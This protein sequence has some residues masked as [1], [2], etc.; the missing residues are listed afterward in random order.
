MRSVIRLTALLFLTCLIAAPALAQQ[1][2]TV[3]GTV[4]NA[5]GKAVAG[6]TIT[7]EAPTG[8]RETRSGPDGKFSMANVPSGSYTLNVRADGFV[9]SRTTLAVSA[10][11]ATLEV[12]L[13]PEP[14]FTEV[15]SV[16]PN[17]RSA[18]ESYQPTTVLG[19]QDLAVNLKGTLGATLD[20]EPG[21]ATRS[22]GP[23]PARPVIRGLDG[24]RVLVLEN[25]NRMGDLS[26]QS[27]DHGVNVNPASAQKIEVV[28]GPATLLYGANAIGGL[29]NV[30]TSAIPT[31]VVPRPAA[32]LTFD[33]GSAA[34]EGGGAGDITVGRGALAA[35]FSA[36][37]RRSGD[38]KAPDGTVPNSF[39][40]AGFFEGGVSR[41]SEHGYVGGSFA[42][43]RT[44]YGIPFVEEGET[45][46][47]PRRRLFDI[48][49][50][51]RDLNGFFSSVRA[52]FG[53][54]RYQHDELDGDVVATSFQNNTADV[55]VLAN[56][57]QVGR[58][59]GTIG[60][61]FL[62]R[63]FDVQGEEVLSPAVDQR[64]FAGFVYEE[65]SLTN[66]LTLQFGGRMDRTS[67]RPDGL[68]N[69]DF[70]N[71]SGSIGLLMKPTSQ[72]T[73][74]FSLANA[75]RNP[76]LEEL[77]FHG[78]HPGN[79]VIENGDENLETE[80]ATGFDTSVRWQAA[81]ASGE[82][83]YFFNTVN[84]FIFRQLTGTIDPDEGLPDSF[85]TQG[86]ARLQGIESHLDLHVTEMVWFEGGLDYVHGQLTALDQPLPRIPPLR[87][88]AGVRFQR[89]ALQVG[90]D[91]I[92]TAKQDR[93]FNVGGVGETPT[94][95][96]SLAK[97]FAA[98]S[99][100]RGPATSTL[101]VHLDNAGNV[102]YHN[103]L[104]YL[105]DLAP[106]VGRDFRVTYTVSF[107]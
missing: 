91:G 54:R 95:G 11:M 69:R 56:H 82:V 22:F 12:K 106:E 96:Y 43:D 37:G 3:S 99:F 107:R 32:N 50:E 78:P 25:G 18:F 59:K 7:L 16:S 5:S 76:A 13:N 87:G 67:F 68:T 73:V 101:A 92:F 57:R 27:G 8:N 35:H 26:S 66:T 38:F 39:S 74:A 19:G 104:N 103:H 47:D 94:A 40:R 30:I 75:S 9:T 72:L 41:V 34:S 10:A 63:S 88:R 42:F 46:L 23:G 90:V 45:N 14:H 20:T 53:V 85:F 64:G 58:L 21:V 1:A 4:N 98:Y 55:N 97:I 33:L 44:H 105:K 29:V 31:T 48:R 24:D 81:R 65:A 52:S 60:G 6:A 71:A 61:S 2:S 49:A 36:S 84:N 28:R 17:A 89:A 83:T 79:A 15:V 100:Q 51:Q 80:R 102:L 62:T 93:I 70:T 86:D 77:Y